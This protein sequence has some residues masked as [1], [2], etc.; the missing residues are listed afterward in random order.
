MELEAFPEDFDRALCVVAHPDDMEYGG[1]AAIARWTAQGKRV[2]YL[3]ATRGEAGIDGMAPEEAAPVREREQ[4]ESAAVVGVDAVEFL[5]HRDGVL[6]Y[7]LA[8]RR[9]IAA[10]IRRHRPEVVVASN[11]RETW[12]GGL[13]NQADH[14]AV[15]LATVDAVR[16]AGNRWVFQDLRPEGLEPWSGV[17]HVAVLASPEATHGVDVADHF[18]AGVA[19]LRC[20]AAY[21]EGLGGDVDPEAFLRGMAEAEGARLGV[22]LAVSFELLRL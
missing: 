15:G 9:D 2:A 7:G 1:A 18:D 13:L 20:H 6:E 16:D 19:S 4:R 10:A 8:L 5:D 22:R 3:L 17:R 11:F 14:R 21:L 12:P